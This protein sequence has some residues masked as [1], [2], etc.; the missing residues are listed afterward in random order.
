MR[1]NEW[2]FLRRSSSMK[3]ACVLWLHP[4]DSS[5]ALKTHPK[6]KSTPALTVNSVSGVQIHDAP[7][8][9]N[10]AEVPGSLPDTPDNNLMNEPA[11]SLWDLG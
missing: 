6:G 3:R 4:R 1:N 10:K 8:A 9:L 2:L 7:Y 11:N 5:T